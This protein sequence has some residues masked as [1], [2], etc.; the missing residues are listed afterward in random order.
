MRFSYNLGCRRL[1]GDVI[2]PQFR[3]QI[4]LKLSPLKYK[5][6]LTDLPTQQYLVN[7][8]TAL[9]GLN[10]YLADIKMVQRTNIL[11]F[12]ELIEKIDGIIKICDKELI[13]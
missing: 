12:E 13:D 3:E 10:G 1:V 8:L 5:G 11:L 4:A 2:K 7:K 9:E 6:N